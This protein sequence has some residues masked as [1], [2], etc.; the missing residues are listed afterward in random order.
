MERHSEHTVPG[1]GGWWVLTDFYQDPPLCWPGNL[2]GES[3][4]THSHPRGTHS[5]LFRP[6]FTI[7]ASA[8]ALAPP[9]PMLLLEN[10][11]EK[12]HGWGSR[13]G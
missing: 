3:S 13:A 2:G 11:Q 10:L 5:R 1:V 9:S 7:R 6:W 12:G 8:R 4:S